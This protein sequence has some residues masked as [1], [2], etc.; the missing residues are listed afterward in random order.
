M[1]CRGEEFLLK[2][3]RAFNFSRKG[4]WGEKMEGTGGLPLFSTLFQLCN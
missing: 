1:V 2:K 4:A 3:S